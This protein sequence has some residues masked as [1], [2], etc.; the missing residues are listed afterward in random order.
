MSQRQHPCF[1][2]LL[3]LTSTDNFIGNIGDSVQL[4]GGV[5]GLRLRQQEW[6]ISA[7]SRA[8]REG[9]ARW[10]WR[11]TEGQPAHL[12]VPY[13]HGRTNAFR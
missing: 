8:Q 4:R 11:T 10:R 1:G 5:S 7:R 13:E 6:L 2:C 9:D 12:A 3:V